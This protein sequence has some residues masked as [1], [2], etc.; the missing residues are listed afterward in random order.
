MKFICD[1]ML[2][3]LAKYLRIAGIDACYSNIYSL[4][5]VISKAVSEQRIILSRRTEILQSEQP[6]K[7]YF[8]KSDYPLEQ[9]LD[10]FRH[11]NLQ[12]DSSSFFTRC[13]E[14]NQLLEFVEKASI[15]G[16]VPA[17]VFSTVNEF[18]RCP[19]CAKIYWKGTHYGN[20]LKRLE[21]VLGA[22]KE[23]IV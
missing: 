21:K 17:Y 14:C 6:V 10:V 3:K 8:I 1:T 23:S 11:F 15:A 5:H 19:Q 20:M 7:S 12:S 9:L 22:A 2:G 4:P 13:L 16:S 18:A